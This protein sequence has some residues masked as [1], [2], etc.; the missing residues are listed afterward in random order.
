MTHR[1]TS[2]VP[3]PYALSTTALS[4]HMNE[5]T[6]IPFEKK[7]KFISVFISNCGSRR[8]NEYLQT[9]FHYL[10]VDS[11]GR[12]FRNISLGISLTLK[13]TD[14]YLRKHILLRQ[15]KCVLTF[16]NTQ[17]WDYVTEKVYHA[18]DAGTLP[19]YWGAPNYQQFIPLKSV[20]NVDDFKSPRELAFH[21]IKLNSNRTAYN[22]YMEWRNGD[23]GQPF[24]RLLQYSTK[25]HPICSLLARMRNL[26]INPYLTV[27]ARNISSDDH[28]QALDCIQCLKAY[29]GPIF[30]K[31]YQDLEGNPINNQ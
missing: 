11:Y 17:E 8:R 18:F 2:D 14:R 12:C 15:Y 16:E 5:D 3:I 26:W 10:Q 13:P 27:W 20:I 28:S 31:T 30:S 22:E 19:V 25:T 9:L 24:H 21:V 29:T 4:K 6:L 7:A 23:I 1:L